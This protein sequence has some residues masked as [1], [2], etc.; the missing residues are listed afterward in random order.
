MKNLAP[1][2]ALSL[3]ACGRISLEEA[4]SSGLISG[5]QAGQISNSARVYENNCRY[6]GQDTEDLA[7][8]MEVA[9]IKER[10]LNLQRD[11]AV[12]K[13]TDTINP[14][15]AAIIEGNIDG[16]DLEINPLLA[17]N[18][19]RYAKASP[20]FVKK[21]QDSQSEAITIFSTEQVKAKAYLPV[22]CKF[23]ST[24]DCGRTITGGIYVSTGIDDDF[25]DCT[26]SASS[27]L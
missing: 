18:S 27:A 6:A 26:T 17:D 22:N 5:E 20:E 14:F 24:W 8:D 3:T 2:L 15:T 16:L 19:G 12:A 25:L 1:A 10:I 21:A 7:L 23:T 13:R 4:R 9:S 11:I